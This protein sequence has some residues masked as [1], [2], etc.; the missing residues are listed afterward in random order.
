MY[1]H[2]VYGGGRVGGF[3]YIDAVLRAVGAQ[4]GLP[5]AHGLQHGPRQAHIF[6]R[7]SVVEVAH[8]HDEQRQVLLLPAGPAVQ[9]PCRQ[10]CLPRRQSAAPGQLHRREIHKPFHR[11]FPQS[12]QQFVQVLVQA[13]GTGVRA[14]PQG[15]GEENHR[16]NMVGAKY[17]SNALPGKHAA[18][19]AAFQPPVPQGAL[20]LPGQPANL[21]PFLKEL[22]GYRLAGQIPWPRQK[23]IHLLPL[24]LSGTGIFRKCTYTVAPAG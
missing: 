24:P 18:A 2:P 7:G 17:R 19:D 22:L 23:Y 20:R 11:V 5:P 6:R 10:R 1:C 12:R 15:T 16:I 4:D 8:P 21:V 9:F 3:Q 13:F 14:F